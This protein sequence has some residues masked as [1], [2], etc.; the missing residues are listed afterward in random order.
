MAF[1]SLFLLGLDGGSDTF[2]QL[3][4][5]WKDW[6]VGSEE[7]AAQGDQESDPESE[8]YRDSF[9]WGGVADCPSDIPN[10]HYEGIP[11][12]DDL[13]REQEAGETMS[14]SFAA[15]NKL[16]KVSRTKAGK[17]RLDGVILLKR[18][19]DKEGKLTSD[20]AGCDNDRRVFVMDPT[21]RKNIF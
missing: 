20:W 1:G 11:V 9:H 16:Y 12:D 2:E 21:D 15:N 14:G 3:S 4:T 7:T 6:V 5:V 19:R 10:C 18:L 13:A 17:I 8:S